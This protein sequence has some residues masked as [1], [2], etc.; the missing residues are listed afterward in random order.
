MSVLVIGA[1]GNVGSG[2]MDLLGSKGVDALAAQHARP[3]GGAKGRLFDFTDPKTWSGALEG[4]DKLFMIPMQ[5]DPF[6]ERTLIPLIDAAKA[7]GVR[8][9][10]FLTAMA[11]DKDW[12]VLKCAE[13]HLMKSDVPWTILRPNFLMQNFTGSMKGA[14]VNGTLAMPVGASRCSLVDTRDCA[15]MAAAA[16]LEDGHE[17]KALTLTGPESLGWEEVADELSRVA[18]HAV[19]FVDV[20]ESGF[21]DA[22]LGFG[23]PP[24]RVE[25]MLQMMRAFRNGLH[26]EVD[27]A[28]P[29]V[30]GRPARS[31]AT[32]CS[33][34]AERLRA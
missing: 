16:L 20:P 34:H 15:E 12:R 21:R 10:V 27:L 1:S 17:G 3:V 4:V 25:Q 5:G 26:E 9:I 8:R 14:V 32:F 33:D 7:S 2:L 28:I 23:T 11:L 31:F 29:E 24:Y 18:G 30:L 19:K 22:L 13:D 6:P